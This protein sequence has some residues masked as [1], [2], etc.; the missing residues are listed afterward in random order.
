V[1]GVFNAVQ[2]EGDLVGNVIFYGRGAGA[3]PTTSAIIADVVELAR[4]IC[5]GASPGPGPSFGRT[6]AIR[7]MSHVVT[8]YYL[9]MN[10]TDSPGVLAQIW[11]TM[12]SASPR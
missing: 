10:V 4:N 2:V 7:P 9:R 5:R 11:A 6:K 8:R 3:L 1:D 12:P